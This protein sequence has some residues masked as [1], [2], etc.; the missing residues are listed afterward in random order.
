MFFYKYNCLNNKDRIQDL[1]KIYF[2]LKI[3]TIEIK[4][5]SYNNGKK[6][7]C[8]KKIDNI[9]TRWTAFIDSPIWELTIRT[10]FAVFSKQHSFFLNLFHIRYR[11]NSNRIFP[12]TFVLWIKQPPECSSSSYKRG[13]MCFTLP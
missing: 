13:L 7:H 4:M 12:R 9:N 6:I 3:V 11:L 2:L 8:Y 1:N 5:K 10:H